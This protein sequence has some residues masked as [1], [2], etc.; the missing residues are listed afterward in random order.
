MLEPEDSVRVP[1]PDI[2]NAIEVAPPVVILP[3]IVILP[4]PPTVIVLVP[5]PPDWEVIAPPMV[6]NEEVLSF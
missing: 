2:V 1:L 4:A 3:P 6:N 5:E